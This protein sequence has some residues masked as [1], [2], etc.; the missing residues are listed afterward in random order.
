MV[1]TDLRTVLETVLRKDLL[2]WTRFLEPP[3]YV[4]WFHF[5]VL[6]QHQHQ[7]KWEYS[8]TN[9]FFWIWLR[10]N[11]MYTQLLLRAA[12]SERVLG[13]LRPLE[14]LFSRIGRWWATTGGQPTSLFEQRSV[15]NESWNCIRGKS[16]NCPEMIILLSAAGDPI[17][18]VQLSFADLDKGWS[19]P[20]KF[21]ICVYLCSFPFLTILLKECGSRSFWRSCFIYRSSIVGE[22]SKVLSI[23]ANES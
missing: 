19:N 22:N 7:R 18:R 20:R 9:V 5:A 11:N 4:F 6:R 10:R 13:E 21:P 15:T 8:I 14:S 16:P 2:L 12:S 23:F 3:F 17:S 1:V